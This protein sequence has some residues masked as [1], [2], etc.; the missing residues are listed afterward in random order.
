MA[1]KNKKR[2][3]RKRGSATKRKQV[4]K[5]IKSANNRIFKQKVLR[6]ISSK[7]E[8]KEAFSQ[9]TI[10]PNCLQST[11]AGL[12]NNYFSCSPLAAGL[13]YT[14]LSVPIGTGV[15]GRIGNKVSTK[16]LR[17]RYTLCNTGY[18]VTTN[19]IPFPTIV[20]L[21]FYKAKGSG[22][23]NPPDLGD[24][25]GTNANF[26]DAPGA[27]AG[28]VGN[29]SDLNQRMN[30]DAYTYLAHR[31]HKVGFADNTQQPSTNH[32]NGANNDYKMSI[33]SSIDLTRFYSKSLKFDDLA[34]C[35]TTGIWCVIQCVYG[36]GSTY[37]NTQQPIQMTV[38]LQY[39]YTDM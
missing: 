3:Y 13:P 37:V 14:K 4:S 36:N 30:N 6:A 17:L 2:S 33:V 24:L 28:F 32:A 38:Q 18:N 20:R 31:T 25:C 34:D 35:F 9:F 16:K 39:S 26:F 21:Y 22:A 7:A 12:S 8:V 10:L 5:A 23:M 19:V 27:N 1:Y 29:I 15:G 11:T